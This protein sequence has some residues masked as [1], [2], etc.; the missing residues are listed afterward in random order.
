MSI[1]GTSASPETM[2]FLAWATRAGL[3][4]TM[5][6]VDNERKHHGSAKPEQ[7]LRARITYS[8]PPVFETDSN[9]GP[10]YEALF[11]YRL[12]RVEFDLVD[13]ALRGF[14]GVYLRE[15]EVEKC[16][17]TTPETDILWRSIARNESLLFLVKRIGREGNGEVRKVANALRLHFTFQIP[18]IMRTPESSF[19]FQ[20]F[21]GMSLEQVNWIEL[22]TL[23]LEIPYQPEVA[24]EGEEKEGDYEA[25]Q[26]AL[27]KEMCLRGY[28]DFGEFG[29][30]PLF[31]QPIH[32]LCLDLADHCLTTQAEVRQ[33]EDQGLIYCKDEQ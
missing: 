17:Y 2:I 5:I 25:M 21:I 9:Y 6:E 12:D 27:L 32:E 30:H 7:V 19:L 10:L 14:Y 23:V 8:Q 33:Q 31:T 22:A 29:N 26:L 18:L 16:A 1:R 13:W 4:K 24:Q 15:A 11:N 28:V 3:Q 20:E